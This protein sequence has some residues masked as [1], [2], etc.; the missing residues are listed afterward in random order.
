[1]RIRIQPTKIKIYSTCLPLKK[2]CCWSGMCIPDPDFCGSGIG[3]KLIPDPGSKRPRSP[4]PDP[5][6]W[7]KAILWPPTRR[8]CCSCRTWRRTRCCAS[9]AS[10]TWACSPSA[11]TTSGTFWT[12]WSSGASRPASPSY[13]WPPPPRTVQPRQRWWVIAKSHP[14]GWDLAE[15]GWDLAECG[16]D[17]AECGWDLTG[18]GWDLTG[19][20]WDLSECG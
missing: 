14:R 11:A 18:C 15:C 6:R 3:K 7:K 4:D 20:R 5:Q 19:C 10:S 1:M 17:L 2:H 13:P 12:W 16:W 8:R 9:F